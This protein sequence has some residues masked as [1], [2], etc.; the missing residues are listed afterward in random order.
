MKDVQM[1]SKGDWK[2]KTEVADLKKALDEAK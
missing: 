1:A 2:A